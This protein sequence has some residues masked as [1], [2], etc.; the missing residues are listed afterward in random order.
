M[1]EYSSKSKHLDFIIL[2]M[3]CVETSFVLAYLIRFGPNGFVDGNLFVVF[4]VIIM[5]LHLVVVFALEG[6]SGI[7]KRGYGKELKKVLF[8]N[9]LIL[10]GAILLL[11]FAHTSNLYS[12]L[13][14]GYFFLIDTTLMYL[15]R[16]LRKK[17]LLGTARKQNVDRKML[18]VAYWADAQELVKQL[19]KFHYS[20]FYLK[21]ICILDGN[22]VGEN[23]EGI[24]VV[25]D[26][27]GLLDYVKL[28]VVDSVFIKCREEERKRLTDTLYHMGVS[29][30]MSL[31]FFLAGIPNATMENINGITVIT[32]AMHQPTVRQKVIKRIMDICGG[33]VGLVLT[34]IICIIFGPIIVAQSPGP[35]FF[36]QQR[37][38]Q[39]GRKFNIYKFRSMYPDAEARKA[40]LMKE[41]KMSG[42]MFKMDN[43]PR[44]IP[45]GR[46]MRKTSLDE[47]PQFW[48]VLKG[49]MSLVGTRPPTLDEWEKYE[50]HHR[51][52]LAIKPGLT[53][54]W[55]ISGR[56]D[57]T[58]FEEVV[59]LDKKYIRCFCI[60]QDIKIILK[61]I[62]VVLV[63]R[64]A[65]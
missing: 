43:D 58:D 56:S 61:T 3:L 45:I 31:D 2:D 21:G 5:L 41:N 35:I 20:D 23:I 60:S 24:K 16:V 22:H 7:L 59:E 11:F 30:H 10:A 53:G 65:S 51:A 63:G 33:L 37:V 26:R 62:W 8:H 55:Q 6:Y 48:N 29:V 14:M 49:E 36:K 39:N 28:H 50:L 25:T 4:N 32:A 40:E 46:F 34:G 18:L 44:I 52:R 19:E 13:V 9:I 27:N 64:G 54:L 15:V 17:W 12:R 57:I 38:G 47:F 1:R 42:L